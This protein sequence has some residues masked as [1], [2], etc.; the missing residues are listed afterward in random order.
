MLDSLSLL[1]DEVFCR[2]H[3]TVS[4]GRNLKS[5]VRQEYDVGETYASRT[6]DTFDKS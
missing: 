6:K 2:T 5:P 1:V 3:G 4:R